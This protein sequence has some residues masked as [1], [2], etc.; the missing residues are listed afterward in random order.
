MSM[1]GNLQ[2]SLASGDAFDVRDFFV[3]EA[4]S[5][6]FE[7]TVIAR[8]ES[9]GVDFE[10]AVGQEARFVLRGGQVGEPVERSWTGIC[11]DLD[12]TAGEESGTSSYRISIVPTLWLAT[13]RRNYRIFQH[14]S[15]PEIVRRLLGE[16][17]IEPRVQLDA[18]V[19][20]KRKY[21]AQYGES[22]Y[23]FIC[24]MLGDVGI[25]FYFDTSGAVTQLVLSDAPQN[26]A[27]RARPIPFRDQP[28][29]ADRTFVTG[30][31]MG[32]R[33]RPGRLTLR[34]H[35][36]RRPP[37]Y[38]L[39]AT[40]T[41]GSDVEA[42]LERFHFEPGAFLFQTDEGDDS[43]TADDRGKTRAS[44]AEGALL[45]RKRLEAKR[46][47]ATRIRF[48]TNAHDLAPGVVLAVLDHPRP[49][50]GGD[51]PL[52]VTDSQLTGSADEAWSQICEAQSA[53]IPHRPAGDVPKPSAL[54]VESATVV[55]PAGE[56]IHCDEFG[57]VRVQFHWDRE[58]KR[59]EL[60][61][62]WIH[63]AQA[64]GGAGYGLVNVPRIG[65]EVLVQFLGGDPD[66]PVIVGRVFNNLQKVPYKL[67]EH[68]TRS[69]W[70]S[71]STHGS[72][73]FNELMF[74]DE[75]GEEL[76]SLRAERDLTALVRR[77]QSVTVGNDRELVVGRNSTR[78]VS[79][80]ER[81][82]TGMNRSVV[83]GGDR[84]TEIEGDDSTE[85]GGSL[86]LCAGGDGT[87]LAA[88]RGRLALVTGEGASIVLEGDTIR[89]EAASIEL[90][91]SSAI[92]ASR[93]ID[94]G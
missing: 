34:D 70:K 20:R 12:Q 90:V 32:R 64:W 55:G 76:V 80:N 79:E 23:D 65:Q 11:A 86:R 28:T 84:R 2:V 52:L 29:I 69:G 49:D 42:R 36:Y 77:D 5:S 54:G 47:S 58:A 67:P 91:G 56:E 89:L 21:R 46:A 37:D 44:E 88:Q 1:T 27:P 9:A 35:D 87:S 43:P 61:S 83:V 71:C 41:D 45:A 16:W 14:L 48:R 25:S 53:E 8:C 66:R 93:A 94:E 85:V 18:A 22:D 60:S 74:E 72:G 62:C 4:M 51:H 15:E 75:A 59:N 73:G 30:L 82:V 50:L 63:V 39:L 81:V 7:V 24:R 6:L 31:Q 17:K 10:A 78:K 26:S 68:K 38:P 40:A 3:H 19:Y 13:Q 92:K 33:V 57:R